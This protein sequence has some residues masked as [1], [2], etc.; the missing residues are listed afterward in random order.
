MTPELF[1][2]SLKAYTAGFCGMVVFGALAVLG[3]LLWSESNSGA[4]PQGCRAAKKAPGA[5]RP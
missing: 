3:M 5:V 1:H 2:D 4:R